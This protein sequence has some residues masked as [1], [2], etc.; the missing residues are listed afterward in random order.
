MDTPILEISA[1]LSDWYPDL[2]RPYKEMDFGT[3][4]CS[5]AKKAS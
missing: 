2:P 3:K 4:Q 5:L 1:Q